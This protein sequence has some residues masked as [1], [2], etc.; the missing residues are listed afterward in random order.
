MAAKAVCSCR[1]AL[2][3][4][5]LC[6]GCGGAPPREPEWPDEHIEPTIAV[7]SWQRQALQRAASDGEITVESALVRFPSEA[8]RISARSLDA[9]GTPRTAAL[10]SQLGGHYELTIDQ[11]SYRTD[12][13]ANGAT[14]AV[15][16]ESGFGV[17]LRA[18]VKAF[19]R[20]IDLADLTAIARAA[21]V[22]GLNGSLMFETIGIEGSA[23]EPL[24][25]EPRAINAESIRDAM[26]VA[27]TLRALL[28][29]GDAGLRVAAQELRRRPLDA[30]GSATSRL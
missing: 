3:G 14:Q 21:D 16:V 17:R 27:S 19:Q 2:I 26:K 6:T 30:R 24:L 9:S 15:A 11:L 12:T 5:L 8:L 1:A 28:E 18:R 23:L 13:H 29:A 22:G 7:R 20:G 4:A 10:V 25:P